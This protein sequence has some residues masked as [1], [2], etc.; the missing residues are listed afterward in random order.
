LNRKI[1]ISEKAHTDTIDY[2]IKKDFEVVL[3]KDQLRPYD[4]VS[5]H[6]D[7]FMFYDE[8]L[9][10]ESDVTLE[11]ITCGPLG[12]KYPETVKFNIA[13]VNNHII[14]K[15]D[16][17]DETI[18]RHIKEQA[19]QIIDVKQG[20]AKCSTAVIND[21]IITSDKGIFRACEAENIKSLLIEPGHI[22]LEGLD[23]GFIGGSCVCFDETVFF[24]GDIKKHPDYQRI[25]AFITS[26]GKHIDDTKQ[27]LTDIGSFI[28]I[29]RSE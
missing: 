27:P 17:V 29:E 13:K 1:I 23:H 19:Y 2:F 28:I 26:L 22:V 5:H 21:A 10:L 16:S 24:N 25:Q 15:F 11:G 4:A 6:P 14:C 8:K 7:M 9:F 12:N 20:Y 3:F 18:K